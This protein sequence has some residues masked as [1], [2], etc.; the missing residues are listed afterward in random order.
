MQVLV[1]VEKE[2]KSLQKFPVFI[3]IKDKVLLL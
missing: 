3:K 1:H 2:K